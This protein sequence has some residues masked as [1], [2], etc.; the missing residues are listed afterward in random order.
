M[1]SIVAREP[2]LGRL[3]GD[4]GLWDQ[5]A[6]RL[7]Q[8][9]SWMMILGTVRL[10]CAAGDYASAFLAM[11]RAGWPTLD[12]LVQF[13]QDNSLP[14][15]LVMSW[16]LILGLALRRSG[17]HPYLLGASALTFF[18]L[19]LGGMLQLVEGLSLRQGPTLVVGS[20]TVSRFA[21]VRSSPAD[22]VRVSM[23]AIQLTLELATAVYA[24]CLAM[25]R[26]RI[27]DQPAAHAGSRRRLRGRLAIYLSLGFLVLSM[28]MPLW[29]AYIELLN[30]SS[31]VRD[32]VIS[33]APHTHNPHPRHF[34][35]ER[36]P[37][38]EWDMTIANAVRLASMN[39]IPEALDVYRQIMIQLESTRGA[40]AQ[41]DGRREPLAL[42]LN[43][44]AWVLATCEDPSLRG[45]D[46]ACTY[47]R[48]A[49]KLAPE[50]GTY[51]NT[52]GVVCFRLGDWE[53]ASEAIHES[54]RLRG[55]QADAFDWFF[56][57]M[58]DAQQG[59]KD[60]AREWYE[61][62]VD[63]FHNGHEADG[64]LYRFQVEAAEVLGLPRPQPPRI[65]Q[66]QVQHRFRGSPASHH[67]HM[68]PAT[69]F[70]N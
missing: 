20:L 47:A 18:I 6:A 33:T 36:R 22:L 25:R 37:E 3:A 68:Q 14:F 12:V 16:P 52:L 48:G 15:L 31:R 21:L 61:K 40:A 41:G 1:G 2:D 69:R 23:G 13:L 10:V 54:M 5:N 29:T 26:G 34:V 24:C 38:M 27:A 49:V 17:N 11:N 42:V 57:A 56:L 64:E 67:P 46:E 45:P 55:G 51:W 60:R 32:F 59:K 7:L 9:S 65:P 28:R 4:P 35:T 30:R 8:L 43:N 53:S 44:L 63:W 50:E 39:R 58:I 70:P 62:A 66:A 19:S